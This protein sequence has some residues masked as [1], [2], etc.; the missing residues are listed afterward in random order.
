[1]RKSAEQGM[2][3]LIS[4]WDAIGFIA[5]CLVFATFY[6]RDMVALRTLAL[7]SNLAFIVYGLGLGLVPIWLLHALLLPVNAWRL[8]QS[9]SMG[10]RRAAR[11]R[12]PSLSTSP[13][14]RGT[15]PRS[16]G[17]VALDLPR[18]GVRP[19]P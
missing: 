15:D 6:M 18:D 17:V 8:W 14:P 4:A 9:A 7:C 5:A 12:A 19:L 10:L 1:M 16:R 13:A 2:N 11:R 3:A